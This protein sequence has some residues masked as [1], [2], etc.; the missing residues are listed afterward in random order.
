MEYL[1]AAIVLA[2]LLLPAGM[3][4]EMRSSLGSSESLAWLEPAEDLDGASAGT[5]QPGVDD[6]LFT[7]P[8]VRRRLDLLASEIAHL[9]DDDGVMAR[10]FRKTVALTA[11]EALLADESRLAQEVVLH[12][13]ATLGFEMVD[14]APGTYR[15]WSR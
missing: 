7:L 10:A 1:L 6:G 11:Y 5:D 3:L 13:D 15:E 4:R 2:V 14:E 8:F 9:D 12:V